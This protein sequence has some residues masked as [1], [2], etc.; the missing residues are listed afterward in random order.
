MGGAVP[1]RWGDVLELQINMN[2]IGLDHIQH[3]EDYNFKNVL[4]NDDEEET[5]I[6]STIGHSCN[7]FEIEEFSSKVKS[8]S[9]QVSFLSY[10]VRS[11]PG[12]W[13]EFSELLNSLNMGSFKFTV[14]AILASKI[15][16]SQLID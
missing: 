13:S 15:R 4:L 11:L 1:G 10:N 6:Y 12:K 14:V 16:I 8:L 5:T 9:K 3:N 7:Y 2:N